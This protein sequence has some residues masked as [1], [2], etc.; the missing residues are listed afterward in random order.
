MIIVRKS[1]TD[2]EK[3]CFSPQPLNSRE[4]VCDD[5]MTIEITQLTIL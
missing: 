5:Y 1:T 3:V 2:V 4:N